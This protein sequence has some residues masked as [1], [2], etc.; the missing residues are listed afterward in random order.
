VL[1]QPCAGRVVNA[2]VFLIGISALG[3]WIPS[4]LLLEDK[5]N[6]LTLTGNLLTNLTSIIYFRWI[7]TGT[8]SGD[9]GRK[10]S[11]QGFLEIVGRSI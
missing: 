10:S 3:I 2:L 6:S 7:L 5:M 4:F 1:E 9:N 8:I 11:A